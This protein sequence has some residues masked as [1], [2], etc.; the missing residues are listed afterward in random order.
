MGFL[1]SPNNLTGE[2]MTQPRRR[3]QLSLDYLAVLAALAL[4]LVVRLG[5]IKQ[6]P[7]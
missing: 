3:F 5:V 4:A 1:F 7:W 6:V 2:A